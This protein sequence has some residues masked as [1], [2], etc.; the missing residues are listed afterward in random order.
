V[1]GFGEGSIVKR[2]VSLLYLLLILLL[3]R[4]LPARAWSG[5]VIGVAA[6]CCE[7]SNQ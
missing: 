7:A 1:K 4:P 6:A 3:A 5:R 2:K